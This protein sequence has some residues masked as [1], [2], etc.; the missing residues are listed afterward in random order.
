MRLIQSIR[1]LFGDKKEN[2]VYERVVYLDIPNGPSIRVWVSEKNSLGEDHKIV[3]KYLDDCV[4]SLGELSKEYIA[5]LIVRDFGSKI[6]AA[7]EVTTFF[8]RKESV[9]I[10]PNWN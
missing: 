3:Q 2:K 7:V 6:I 8:P 5:E 1:D 9:L 10:Y 4:E